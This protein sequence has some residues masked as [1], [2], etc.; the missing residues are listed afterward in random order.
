MSIQFAKVQPGQFEEI[1][2]LYQ[3]VVASMNA[4]GLRQWTWEVYPT[5]KQLEEDIAAGHLY[6]AEADG[7]LA[8]AFVLSDDMA[9]EYSH[10][11]WH[12]GV[13]PV[14]MHRFAVLPSAFGTEAV[15]SVLAFVREEA[16][17]LG[18]DSLRIDVCAEDVQMME[19]C[20][21]EMTRKV[22]CIHF[23]TFGMDYICF[24]L[25]L[26]SETPKSWSQYS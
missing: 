24:E 3:N 11:E 12:Y 22:G 8:G 26:S 23:E 4:S 21:A 10:M 7:V 13:K 16:V 1:C 18:F 20:E 2:T 14:T 9:E 17:R 15:R 6:R 25:P 19:I 5:S